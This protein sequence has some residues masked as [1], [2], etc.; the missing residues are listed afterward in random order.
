[1]ATGLLPEDRC[2]HYGGAYRPATGGAVIA[3]RSP[4]TG[5][6]IATVPDGDAADV[7]AAAD[8]AAQAFPA[9]SR[10]DPAERARL[11][12]G[13]AE[14]LRGRMPELAAIESAVT[15]RAIREMQAQM[16]R[17]PEW[18]EYF[19]GIVLGLEGESNR[20]KGGF[21]TYTAYEP[22]GVCALLTPWN[23]PVL[24]LVKKLAAALAAG[25][26]CL[27]K[28]SELAPVSPL[29]L[30]AWCREAGLPPGTVN[31]VTGGGHTGQ[32]V[33]AA[34]AVQRIDL[35]GGTATGRRVAAAAAERLIPCTLELGGKAPVIVA[36]DVDLDEAAAG[37]AFAAFVAA[38]QTCVSGTRF[39]VDS[40]IYADFVARLA[41]RATAI[42][43]GDPA[44]PTTDMGPVISAAARDRCLDHV[45]AARRDGARLMAGGAAPAGLPARLRDGFFVAPTVLADV[46][47]QSRLFREEVF[48]PVVGVTP[49]GDEDEAIALANDTPFALGGAVWTRDVGRA[50]RLAGALRAGVV[51]INDHHKNDPR[52]VWG[53]WGDS[54]YGKENGWDALRSYLR[55]RSVVVRTNPGFDDWFAGGARY[56]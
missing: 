10:T 16:S 39:I 24:I 33:C 35:T 43:V 51:W 36:A 34:A 48:G 1:M 12:R 7:A 54:G 37:A 45:A 32:L 53:G 56:G 22:H 13:L 6:L 2:H 26:V 11:L 3:V 52:S 42:R 46:G 41:A 31:V 14:I 19:A 38:G 23:H 30:A 44:D 47:R 17:I 49:Y 27:V 20:V 28:P 25:N 9:W 8:A 5:E 18:I 21:L 29:I 50:H 55:K 40:A 4:A 15:G